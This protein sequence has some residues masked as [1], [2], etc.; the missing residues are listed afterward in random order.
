MA[1]KDCL[2]LLEGDAVHK[3]KGGNRDIRSGLRGETAAM[4]IGDLYPGCEI[5]G[6]TKGQFCCIDILEHV[7]KQTGPADVTICTWSAASGDIRAAHRMLK[8]GNIKSLRFI[9]DFS[10]KSRKPQF[11]KELIDTFGADSIRVTSIHAK[12]MTVRSKDFNIVIRTSMNLN[13][14]PRFE[15][16]EISDDENMLGFMDGV[17]DEIW[18]TQQNHEG[19]I[20]PAKGR[21]SFGKSF[22]D[23]PEQNALNFLDPTGDPLDLL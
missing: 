5:Y 11:C 2:K 3:R 6:F 4:V 7:L 23:G 19:F 8:M 15:N 12:F 9:V 20:S 1:K 14:N 21:Q 17:V 16:F 22:S 13:F 18:R 10:F